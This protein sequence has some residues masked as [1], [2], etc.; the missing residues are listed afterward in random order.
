MNQ[1]HAHFLMRL[2]SQ[3]RVRFQGWESHLHILMQNGWDIHVSQRIDHCRSD[4]MFSNTEIGMVAT[5]DEFDMMQRHQVHELHVT[6]ITNP[7][8]TMIRSANRPVIMRHELA[9]APCFSEAHPA[10]WP[11]WNEFCLA[12]ILQPVNIEKLLVAREDEKTVDDLL[13]HILTKQGPL[14]QEIAERRVKENLIERPSAQIV[15]LFAA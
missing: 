14:R 2:G 11:V 6:R 15:K 9:M 8:H 3:V 5:V 13:A 12:D 7:N 4:I 1:E 10:T